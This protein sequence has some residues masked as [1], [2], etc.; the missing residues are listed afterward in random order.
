MLITLQS[1]SDSDANDFLNYFKET[2]I[3]KPDSEI[4]L[5]NCSYN[6]EGGITV[7]GTNN[8][9]Q[10]K[11]AKDQLRTITLTAGTYTVAG[12]ITEITSAITTFFGVVPYEIERAFRIEA[13]A[14]S[15]GILTLDF[16][17]TPEDW[18]FLTVEKTSTADRTAI[19][20]KNADMMSDD[21]D[22]IIN[23]TSS[24]GGLDLRSW[25][26]GS[27]SDLYPI[28]A[29]ADDVELQPHGSYF[30]KPQQGD[31][32]LRICLEDGIVPT[33][34]SDASVQVILKTDGTFDIFERNTTGTL[35]SI[36]NTPLPSYDEFDLFEIR[37][38]QIEPITQ[39]KKIRYFQNA[40]ELTTKIDPTRDRWLPRP[41]SKLICLG[42][43]DTEKK[44][45]FIVSSGGTY[46][47]ADC[48]DAPSI[49]IT[50]AGSGYL[51]G[52]VI[53][54]TSATSDITTAKITGVNAT[55]GI[56]GF[57]ILA[58]GGGINGAGE[59]ITVLGKISG[60]N[61]CTI[62]TGLPSDSID[63][64][65]SGGA[66][67]YALG[68]ADILLDDGITTVAN[69][70]DIT[71]IDGGNGVD[72]FT[73]LKDLT[74]QISVGDT[75]TIVQGGANDCTLSVNAIDSSVPSVADVKWSTIEPGIDEPLIKQSQ[76]QF[77]PSSGFQ[78]LTSLAQVQGDADPSLKSTGKSPVV[79]NKETDQMLINIEQF[80]LKSICKEGGIQK[81]VAS[82]PF[83][84]RENTSGTQASGYFFYE[85]YNLMYHKLENYGEETHNQMRV[86]MTDAVGNPMSSLKH[87]TTITLDLRPRAI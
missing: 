26:S 66:V 64:T 8:T 10:V 16:Q 4:A 62:T 22:G 87:K 2:V 28:W 19:V 81:A 70:V 37:I 68:N 85:A 13:T 21:G 82:V 38:E 86:R 15:K 71:A 65:A 46:D 1:N 57:Q 29:T 34:I 41:Q 79:D 12:F 5:V 49:T 44:D 60:A 40:T 78:S 6:Y 50:S 25:N 67:P 42:S 69:A 80:Q 53:T 61:N 73:W 9:F 74:D 77:I 54:I 63:I 31:T 76:A 56:T 23:Q 51:D 83:G 59:T 39:S 47:V 75:L 43:F 32:A 3:V 58:H 52:E 48:L 17:Y 35:Q 72:D 45:S 55:G 7:D 33:T 14:D 20:L 11:L 27:G 24:T 84:E 36:M 30:F 18:T